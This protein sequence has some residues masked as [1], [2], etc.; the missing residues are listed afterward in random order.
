MTLPLTHA[1]HVPSVLQAVTIQILLLAGFPLKYVTNVLSESTTKKLAKVAAELIAVI[2][3]LNVPL[4]KPVNAKPLL[5]DMGHPVP[6]LAANGARLVLFS[7]TIQD[8][9]SVSVVL[10]ATLPKWE[11]ESAPW[12]TLI[13]AAWPQMQMNVAYID[14]ISYCVPVRIL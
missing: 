7:H 5:L 3:N 8:N 9:W 2:V 1:Q 14:K 10:L 11:R 13:A 12:L 6:Q 4:K